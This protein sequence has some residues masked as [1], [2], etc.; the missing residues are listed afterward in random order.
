[1]GQ[2]DGKRGQGVFQKDGGV[3]RELIFSLSIL[4]CTLLELWILCSSQGH[5]LVQ[6]VN[7]EIPKYIYI[8]C[9]LYSRR[10]LECNPQN[11]LKDVKYDCSHFTDKETGSDWF[12]PHQPQNLLI[13]L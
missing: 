12:Q 2:G 11:N 5:A 9:R 1:M 8:E 6:H 4:F 3:E 7:L 10:V 13:N